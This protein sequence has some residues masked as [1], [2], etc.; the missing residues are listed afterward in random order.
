VEDWPQS[1]G[2]VVHPLKTA[3]QVSLDECSAHLGL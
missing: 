2:D 1:A 3:D